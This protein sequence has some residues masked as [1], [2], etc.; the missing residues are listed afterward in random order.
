MNI[1]L[2]VLALL[3]G[4]AATGSALGK[5]RRV[6]SVVESMHGVGVSDSQ[7]RVL[8]LL[9]SLGAL[10][11]LIGIWI[12]PVGV[13]AAAGLTLYFIGALIAHARVKAP[14]KE[15]VPP[16]VLAVLALAT[17]LLELAR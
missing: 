5:L 12:M 11:L 10:G 4:V 3:L 2:I 9:E 13:A 16:L 6:P 15:S 1:A 7:I 14:I 17:T 8:A